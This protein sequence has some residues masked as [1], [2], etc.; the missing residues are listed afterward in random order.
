VCVTAA[1]LTVA[2]GAQRVVVFHALTDDPPVGEH[3][4]G[5][6]GADVEGAPGSEQLVGADVAIAASDGKVPVRQGEGWVA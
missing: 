6:D 4:V 3:G 5:A 1:V 2:H